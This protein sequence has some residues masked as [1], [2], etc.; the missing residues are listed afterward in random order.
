MKARAIR[1]AMRGLATT[2]RK[3]ERGRPVKR[4]VRDI[5]D[6]AF[7]IAYEV[8]RLA[9]QL[10]PRSLATAKRRVARS[11][12]LSEETVKD[13]VRRREAA[14]SLAIHDHSIE[15]MARELKSRLRNASA[16]QRRAL[17]NVPAVDLL[18][19]LRALEI[20]GE[21]NID[22]LTPILG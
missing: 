15:T 9:L 14:R 16:K 5:D 19:C 18:H 2:D 11:H 6:R 13:Y 20:D 4:R 8:H 21:K 10:G 17:R 12:E 22:L 3:R 7:A 1:E